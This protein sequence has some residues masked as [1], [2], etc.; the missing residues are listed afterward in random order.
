MSFVN[1][2]GKGVLE[3]SLGLENRSLAGQSHKEIGNVNH[4]VASPLH[5]AADELLSFVF[6]QA[7]GPVGEGAAGF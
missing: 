3:I 2:P 6:A 4:V 5:H 1:P 7:Q